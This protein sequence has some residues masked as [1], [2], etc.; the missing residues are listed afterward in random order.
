MIKSKDEAWTLF[1][2]LSNNFVQHVLTRCRAPVLKAPKIEG[3]F[4]IEHSLD[5]ATQVV[6]VITRKLDQ[7]MVASLTPNFAHM[8]TQPKP[9]SICSSPMHHI[10]YYPTAGNYADVSNE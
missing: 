10:N 8:H 5:V 2:N 9:C 6:D 3:L 7:L 1:E 4:E